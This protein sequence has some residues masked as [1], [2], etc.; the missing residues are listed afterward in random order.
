MQSTVDPK[1]LGTMTLQ[2]VRSITEKV[3]DSV[4]YMYHMNDMTLLINQISQE[5]NI[6]KSR[7]AHE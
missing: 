7:Q 6:R 2:L 3:R 4:F 1:T 5:L